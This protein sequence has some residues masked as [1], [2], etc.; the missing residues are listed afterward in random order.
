VI[1]LW[2]TR[3]G[4]PSKLATGRWAEGKGKPQGV[5]KRW[6]G[7]YVGDDGK[8]HTQRFRTEVEAEQWINKERGKVHTDQW[9]SPDVGADTFG[10]VAEQWFAT[11]Q[12]RKPK[13]LEG[14]RSLLGT[15]VLPEWRDEPLKAINYARLSTWLSGL[16]TGDRSLSASRIRQAHQLIGAVYKYAMKAGLASKNPASEIDR[17]HDLPEERETER[18]YLTLTQLLDLAR[19]TGKYETLTL[20]LGF[21][22]LRFGEA[23]ALK[24]RDVGD[25]ELIVRR[26]VTYVQGLGMT[27]T[28]TKTKRSRHVPVP[29]P[30]W[31]MLSLPDDGDALVF[32]GK[33]GHLTLGEYR[34]VFDKAVT[35]LQEAAKAKQAEEIAEK[36]KTI[37]PEFPTISPHALRHTCA[38]L[39]ISAGA[40]VKVV[41]R[42]LGHATAA[43][44]L[45]TYGH[46]LSDDL[47]G[48]A[49]ALGKAIKAAS[50]P[51]PPS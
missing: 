10:V 18:H 6:R 50:E 13:T 37:T 34:W 8:Q 31:N 20:V 15:V 11:K 51:E 19:E 49:N 1:D 4:S 33:G 39:A 9:V 27:E 46:L 30:V 21:C 7:W 47:A 12:H 14:Y 35:R 22:G 45:D 32:P 25:Q 42:L 36:G 48:V 43:M 44:T 17:R 2:K 16:S 41:Q 28:D 5:G 29:E 38:S 23:I 40:N 3:G 24:R 26:S